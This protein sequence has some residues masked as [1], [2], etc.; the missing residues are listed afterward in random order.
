M[1]PLFCNPKTKI[2]LYVNYSSTLFFKELPPILYNVYQKT[3]EGILINTFYQ[4]SIILN[5]KART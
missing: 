2:M 4:V 1:K 5:T 3:E